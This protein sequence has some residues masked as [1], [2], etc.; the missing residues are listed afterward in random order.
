MVIFFN[1]SNQ[2]IIIFYSS[3]KLDNKVICEYFIRTYTFT[4]D[5]RYSPHVRDI[6]KNGYLLFLKIFSDISYM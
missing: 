4:F 3:I 2:I 1:D 5:S 6:E